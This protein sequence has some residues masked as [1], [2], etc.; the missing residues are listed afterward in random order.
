MLVWCFANHMAQHQYKEGSVCWVDELR[1]KFNGII[2]SKE[3][4]KNT[5]R[6]QF[7]LFLMKTKIVIRYD[8]LGELSVQNRILQENR[9]KRGVVYIF[10]LTRYTIKLMLDQA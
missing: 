6:V 5:T 4:Y 9:E 2:L 10:G 7:S 3:R 1:R 8:I